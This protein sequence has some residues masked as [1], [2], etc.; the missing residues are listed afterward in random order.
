[1]RLPIRK[2]LQV[3]TDAGRTIEGVLTSRRGG[4]LRLEAARLE[5]D[6]RFVD[7]DGVQFVPVGRVLFVTE[8]AS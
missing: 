6:G 8:V 7:V 3:H 4:V 1:M 2:R 5:V